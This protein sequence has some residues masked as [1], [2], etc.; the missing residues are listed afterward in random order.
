MLVG[1]GN[2]ECCLALRFIIFPEVFS[3]FVRQW[4]W[5]ISSALLPLRM[6]AP[7]QFLAQ[8][9][10][11]ANKAECE[12]A[13]YRYYAKLHGKVNQTNLY[14]TVG[15]LFMHRDSFISIRFRQPINYVHLAGCQALD[16]LKNKS[17][18]QI[19]EMARLVCYFIIYLAKNFPKFLTIT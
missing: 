1:L 18:I 4:F 15:A 8:E 9:K 7:S 16:E 11:W 14:F 3:V 5:S 13:E 17:N 19:C 10:F 6:S 2:F 12:D